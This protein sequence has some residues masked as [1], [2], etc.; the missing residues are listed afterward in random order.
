MA[1]TARTML[2]ALAVTL[3][4]APIHA[5]TAMPWIN[6]EFGTAGSV[7]VNEVETFLNQDCKPLGF[8]GIQFLGIQS[9]HDSVL[10]VHVY[11]RR[12]G[13]AKARYKVDLAT[14]P[15]GQFGPVIQAVLADPRARL[16]P[17]HFGEA[18][19]NDGIIIVRK[20]N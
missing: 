1:R 9:G 18:G 13:A 8:D 11:C 12:D 5:A 14:F 4:G 10:H 3:A 17:F 15:K 7:P 6:R 16:G 2:A 19:G 20:L